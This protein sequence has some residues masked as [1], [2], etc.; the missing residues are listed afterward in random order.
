VVVLDKIGTDD[1]L[2]E[3]LPIA[4]AVFGEDG[5]LRLFN[6]AYADLFRLDPA[7]LDGHPGHGDILNRLREARRWPEINDFKSYRTNEAARLKGLEKP[8]SDQLYLPDGTM[9][10]QVAAPLGDG[11]MLSFEDVSKRLEAERALNESAA[12]QRQTLDHIAAGIAVYGA[13]GRQRL[14]NAAFG[15]LWDLPDDAPALG[16][17]LDASRTFFEPDDDWPAK[18]GRL[19]SRLLGRQSGLSRLVR[20]D[21]LVLDAAH[22]PLPDGGALLSYTDVTDSAGLEDAL[23]GRAA[24]MQDAN[25]MKSDF[26]ATLS[27]QVRGPL[28]AITGF[29][30]LLA[31][32]YVGELNKRQAEYAAGIAS[33]SEA[34]A[35]M[36]DAVLDLAGM[37]A[38][39]ESELET[40][41]IDLHAALAEAF[42]MMRERARAKKITLEFDCAPDIGWL[43][44]DAKKLHHS[45]LHLLGNAVTHTGNGGQISLAATHKKGWFE[46]QVADTGAGMKRRDIERMTKP[47]ER[48]ET[49]EPGAG[50]GLTLVDAFVRLQGGEMKISS[51]PS[52]GTRVTC[53]LPAAPDAGD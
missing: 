38:G 16:D 10:R 36:F 11:F 1:A 47:F 2:I 20:T 17:F 28:T 15:A 51:A 41:I 29:S 43:E 49:T 9:L 14:C 52:R 7:W 50:L 33:Q 42:N 5:R 40:E 30:E 27:H 35:A 3:A 8:A 18:R 48:G 45:V 25:R 21:G 23:R 34:L 53:R 6:K 26:L 24:A 4:V 19:V 31:G 46:I 39:L 22:I 13:D 12:V 32:G 37:E 44:A